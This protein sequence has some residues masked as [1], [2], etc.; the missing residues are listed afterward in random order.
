M[1][2]CGLMSIS[3]QND[4]WQSKDEFAWICKCSGKGDDDAIKKTMMI[5]DW[6]FY[7][8]DFIAAFGMVFNEEGSGKRRHDETVMMK[9]CWSNCTIDAF[10]VAWWH[11][12]ERDLSDD[13]MWIRG[14]W[15]G[16]AASSRVK[17]SAFV[18]WDPRYS[19]VSSAG[20]AALFFEMTK[21]LPRDR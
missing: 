13:V 11:T 19:R 2:D 14:A 5:Y 4:V 10:R 17:V 1:V 16:T 3:H 21:V 8:D 20:R 18:R 12:D 15:G 7:T 6:R 9:H